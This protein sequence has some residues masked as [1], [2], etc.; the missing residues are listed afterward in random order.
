MPG[1]TNDGRD[2]RMTKA[3]RREAA[4]REREELR[5]QAAARRRNRRIAVVA[6]I[7]AVLGV[8]AFAATRPGPD[9]P[10]AEELLARAETASR[11]AGCTEPENV[12]PYQPEDLDAEHGTMPPLSTYPSIPPASGPHSDGTM[13]AGVYDDP[14]P[15]GEVVHSLEH[16]AVAVW[17]DPDAPAGEIERIQA[18][19]ADGANR[20]HVIV[21]PFDYP[22]EG[23][24]GRLSSGMALAAWHTVMTC[25]EPS[26]AAAYGFVDAYRAP[27]G[28]NPNYRGEA[29]EAGLPI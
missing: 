22:D 18:F 29:P 23:A 27:P 15:L 17:Y 26:L 2:G 28:G 14:P 9:I 1:R 21:A 3:E 16:G 10:S 25:R 20:A 19:F 12:G 13:R 7:V 4:R 5:R 6:A 11:D 24:A 8:V